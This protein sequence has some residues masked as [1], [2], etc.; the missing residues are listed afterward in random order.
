MSLLDELN[1]MQREAVLKTEGPVLMLAG[2]GSGKTKALTY[3]IAH[4]IENGVSPYQIL[5]ITFTNKAAREMRER[6]LELVAKDADMMWISTFHSMCVRILRKD[7]D[8]LGFTSS[9]TIYDTDDSKNVLKDVI[10]R[11]GLD[12]KSFQPGKALSEISKQKDNL[13]SYETYQ[14]EA[15]DD[16][17]YSKIAE[18]YKNYQLTLKKNNALDF[19]DI[20]YKT[21]ELFRKNPETIARYNERFMYVMVDEYQDTNTAQYELVKLLAG[22]KQN[23]CVV[24]DDDQSIYG[25]RG[26]N[27][28]NILDYEKDFPSAKIIKLEQNYRSTQTILNAANEVISNNLNR[29]DKKLWTDNG[30]GAEIN[31]AFCENENEESRYV[32]DSIEKINQDYKYNDC[33]ILYRTNAQSRALEDMLVKRNIPYKIY[34]G[35]RF[36]ERKEIKDILAYLRL[37]YNPSDDIA[38]KRVINVPKRGVGPAAL[39]KIDKYSIE[40]DLPFFIALKDLKLKEPRSVSAKLAE[41]INLVNELSSYASENSVVECMEYLLE[42]TGYIKMIEDSSDEFEAASRID[43]IQAF[44]SKA[45]EYESKAESPSLQG[46]LEEISLVADIDN[47][48]GSDNVVSLM[49]VHSSKGL[50]FQIVFL[51]GMEE[52][53]FP[54]FGSINYGGE[55]GIEEE[56]RLFYVGVTRAKSILHIT[57]AKTRL[58]RGYTEYPSSSRFLKEIPAEYIKK[59]DTQKPKVRSKFVQ[60]AQRP[61]YTASLNY[62]R[63]N[64]EPTKK[65]ELDFAEGDMVK[66]PKYGIGKVIQ[67]SSIGKD[68]EVTVGFDEAGNK[69]FMA[70]LS[71]LKKV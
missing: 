48:D 50:E 55:Q 24:G 43:N 10:I 11:L 12:I 54:S 53:L 59:D 18:I 49:T 45:A 51:T 39:E 15:G 35:V 30:N 33:A 13:V 22:S 68:Y 41:F 46:F 34:G 64:I 3:R 2:A 56:R 71:K 47:H 29:K 28:R 60:A 21:V 65:I 69:K 23:L 1:P 58:V 44:I 57:R 19:D 5:A 36:Y 63:S 67:I 8:K 20:I 16:F 32:A 61:Q 37:I 4:L 52:G 17:Y 31:L 26:A 38:L 9:F 14:K 42:K 62:M 40:T 7:I 25:W 70:L 6:V 27:I 66:H